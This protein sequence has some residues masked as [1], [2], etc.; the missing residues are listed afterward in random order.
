[1]NFELIEL[2]MKKTLPN[3]GFLD[4]A[5]V[6]FKIIFENAANSPWKNFF[7]VIIKKIYKF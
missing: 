6:V 7:L 1:M 5:C 2:R 3:N 4:E